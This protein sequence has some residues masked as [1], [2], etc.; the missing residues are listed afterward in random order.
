MPRAASSFTSPSTSSE[1]RLKYMRLTPAARIAPLPGMLSGVL[2][3]NGPQNYRRWSEMLAEAPE[4][5][6]SEGGRFT[7]PETFFQN[8]GSAFRP[9]PYYEA[10]FTSQSHH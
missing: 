1:T 8:G 5:S 4:T 7:V 6:M 2:E 10:L 9:L 3:A